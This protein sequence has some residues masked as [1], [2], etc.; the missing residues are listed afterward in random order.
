M[1][2]ELGAVGH[3]GVLLGQSDLWGL[4]EFLGESTKARREGGE[5][6]EIERQ[7]EP[8]AIQNLREMMLQSDFVKSR[9]GCMHAPFAARFQKKGI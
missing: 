8:I 9:P 2:L 1:G 6:G 3:L 7:S 5:N 4:E